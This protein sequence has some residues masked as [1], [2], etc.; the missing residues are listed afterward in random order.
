M[1]DDQIAYLFNVR[2]ARESLIERVPS[3]KWSLSNFLDCN[4]HIPYPYYTCIV[5]N[6][7]PG[8]AASLSMEHPERVSIGGDSVASSEYETVSLFEETGQSDCTLC[9]NTFVERFWVGTLT[10]PATYD[11]C[12][13]VVRFVH[14]GIKKKNTS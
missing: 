6:H 12:Y 3:Y 1:A 11:N 7:S 5:E 10:S 2:V 14:V 4:I 13:N 8:V 9:M